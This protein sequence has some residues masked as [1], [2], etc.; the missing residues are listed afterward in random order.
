MATEA[1]IARVFVDDCLAR[2]LRG[3][4]DAKTAS[5]AKW[6]TTEL[7]NKLVD[8]GRAAA[9]RLR[10]HGRVPD[11]PGVRELAA[12]RPS[13]AARPRSRRRSSA[14]RWVSDRAR[15]VTFRS[16]QDAGPMRVVRSRGIPGCTMSVTS[17]GLDP[18]HRQIAGKLTGP[19]TKWIVLA[20]WVIAVAGLGSFAGKLTDVQNNETSSWLPDSA[21]STRA[22]DKLSAFQDPNAISTVVVYERTSGLTQDDIAAA[23]GRRDRPAGGD[24]RGDRRGGGPDPVRGRPG[25]ADRGDVRPGQ[26]RLELMPDTVKEIREIA[27]RVTASTCTSPVPAARP[28]T[29]RRRSRGSTPP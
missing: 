2:H 26:E 7:Q 23:R 4:L 1:H 25:H 14:G 22:L 28:P 13:T 3:E 5:M 20:F 17:G 21:E 6:W 10:L 8:R 18:M 29:P 16:G 24:R 27:P 12:S 9:R 19:V 15:D 11:R